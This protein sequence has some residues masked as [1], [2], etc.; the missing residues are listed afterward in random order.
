M[1]QEN[2]QDNG[3][4]NRRSAIF[5]EDLLDALY[6]Q[7][8]QDVARQHVGLQHDLGEQQEEDQR[9]AHVT[10]A[11]EQKRRPRSRDPVAFRG[12]VTVPRMNSDNGGANDRYDQ[13][14]CVFSQIRCRVLHGSLL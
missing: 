10:R 13:V 7:I 4:Q 1:R 9:C 14:P 11:R 12:I 5:D 8:D 3:G 6:L 2:R